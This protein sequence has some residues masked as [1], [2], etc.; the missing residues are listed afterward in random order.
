MLTMQ[1]FL[2]AV[3]LI[4]AINLFVFVQTIGFFNITL[5]VLAAVVG[6][7]LINAIIAVVTCKMLPN[8]WYDYNKKAFQVSKKEVR[9]YEKLGIKKWKH[10]TAELGNLNGFSKNKIEEFDNPEYVKKFILETNKGYIDHLFSIFASIIAAFCMPIRF[11]LPLSIPVA[12]TS[13]II[14]LISVI[15]LRYNMPRLKVMLKFSERKQNNKNK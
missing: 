14:N 1:I 15:I 7:I 6:M 3:V 12:L 10:K 2:I 9:F 11:W 8:K 5:I 4:Y 13:V